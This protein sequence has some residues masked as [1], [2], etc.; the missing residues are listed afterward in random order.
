MFI[1]KSTSLKWIVA[2]I[3]FFKVHFQVDY[4]YGRIK[5]E[6]VFKRDDFLNLVFRI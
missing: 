3:I 5:L 1:L 4:F 6:A 2:E